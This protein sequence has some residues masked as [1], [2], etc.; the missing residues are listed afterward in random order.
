MADVSRCIKA[1][2][3][4]DRLQYETIMKKIFILLAIIALCA[5][6]LTSCKEKETPEEI[7]NPAEIEEPE[8]DVPANEDGSCCLEAAIDDSFSEAQ[9]KTNLSDGSGNSASVQWNMTDRIVAVKGSLYVSDEAALKQGSGRQRAVFYFP[10]YPA[11]APA[12]F[13]YPDGNV[14]YSDDTLVQMS[15]PSSQEAVAGSFADKTAPATGTITSGAIRFKNAGALLTVRFGQSFSRQ[16][17]KSISLSCTSGY[18]SGSVLV[19]GSS[20]TVSSAVS[21]NQSVTL[22]APYGEFL[23]YDTDYYFVVWPGSKSGL[24]ITVTDSDGKTASWT[25]S[26]TLEPE[27]NQ[28]IEIAAFDIPLSKWNYTNV[29]NSG[30]LSIER[31]WGKYSTSAASWNAYFGGIAD[32]D[33][34]CTMDDDYIY[35]PETSTSAARIWKINKLDPSDVSTVASPANPTGYFKTTAARVMDPGTNSL[36]GGKPMLVVSNMVMTE[37]GDLLKLYI[38]NNGTNN[39]PSEWCMNSTATGRRLGDIF[40]IHGTFTDGGFMFKDWNKLWSNGT[41]LVWRT[42]F[43]SVPNYNQEPRN[44]TWNTIKDE[45]GRAAFYPYP[46]QATP[47]NGIYTGTDS[48]YY[49]SESGSN[50]YTWNASTFNA[51]AAAGY[52]VNAGDFNFFEYNGKRYI[53]YV[54]NAGNNDGRF[55]ILQGELSDSWQDL[56]GSKRNV[57]YQASIQANYAFNDGEYHAELENP[58]PK[59]SGNSGIGC[60]ARVIG[61]AVYICAGKQNVGLSLF[62]MSG[63]ASGGTG[64]L[65]V[66]PIDPGFTF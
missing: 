56:L 36:N 16:P 38:Y 25:N 52:Y 39:T 33:R 27:R 5:V 59:Q 37:G 15:I 2:N 66:N 20:A 30:Q 64:G 11:S 10:T 6:S 61:D 53:A 47:Q 22:T 21:T 4:K 58:S 31:V 32:S 46:G 12:F 28:I 14:T 43:T 26:M 63:T 51:S 65:P 18:F 40:T 19:T 29:G 44:P 57:I 42:A 62:K 1:D 54:K 55:Y 7:E 49:V 17:I 45:G 35:I 8:V 34:N 48:A 13:A 23:N 50:V 9:T 41:I 24:T 3:D 60:C